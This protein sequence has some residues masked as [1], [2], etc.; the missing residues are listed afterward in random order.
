LTYELVSYLEENDWNNFELIAKEEIDN[1]IAW[2]QNYC[3]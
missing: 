1:Y 3:N 2:I